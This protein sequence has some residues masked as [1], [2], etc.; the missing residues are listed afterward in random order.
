MP[1]C[2]CSCPYP[3][4]PGRIIA[5]LCSFNVWYQ[6]FATV[7]LGFLSEFPTVVNVAVLVVWNGIW[8]LTIT[9]LLSAAFTDPVAIDPRYR[10]PEE[11]VEVPVE[12]R[13]KKFFK[14]LSRYAVSKPDIQFQMTDHSSREFFYPRY[15]IPC[16]IFKPPR[17]HHC[18]QCQRC[19]PRMDHH[20]PVIATCVHS[21]NHKF[22]L[23]FLFW[24]SFLCVY[25][26]TLIT[27][28]LF[29]IVDLDVEFLI[30]ME[31]FDLVMWL[32]TFSG[33]TNAVICAIALIGFQI[34][35]WSMLVSNQT[36]LES[37]DNK[38]K[39]DYSLGSRV[40]NIETVMGYN[41]L[42]WFVPYQNTPTDGFTYPVAASSE[43][44]PDD[45]CE[46]EY[47]TEEDSCADDSDNE[48]AHDV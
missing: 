12:E 7:Y 43:T 13:T 23:N 19:I 42:L 27:R 2:R 28:T 3:N 48:Y 9:S 39:P 37:N 33:W 22:F 1:S 38:V 5:W 35:L 17:A 30:A 47:E 40:K 34:Y 8:L 18:R 16:K 24:A 6:I 21:H 20:C 29:E 4:F 10:M 45:M 31:Q 36:T 15:C 32:I 44:N 25:A 14:R 41:K 46:C 26:A 11:F